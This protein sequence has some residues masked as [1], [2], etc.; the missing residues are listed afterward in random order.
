[1]AESAD[2]IEAF[3]GRFSQHFDSSFQFGRSKPSTFR[4]DYEGF[5][6]SHPGSQGS[7]IVNLDAVV[8]GFSINKVVGYPVAI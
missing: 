5:V 2:L 3:G 4:K 6:A 7:N 1:M 8:S